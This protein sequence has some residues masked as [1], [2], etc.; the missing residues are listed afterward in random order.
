MRDLVDNFDTEVLERSHEVP[1]LVDF[2]SPSCGP[3]LFLAP[4][5]EKLEGEDDGKWEMVKVNT[6]HHGQLAANYGVSSIPHVQLFFKGKKVSEFVGALPE[7]TLT[8]WLAEFIPTEIKEKLQ[9]IR[10]RLNS[11]ERA[12]AVNDLR[13]FVEEH[14]EEHMGKL[15]LAHEIV[16]T[17]SAAA[18]EMVSEIKLGDLLYEG[19]ENV[20]ILAELMGFEQETETPAGN[21]IMA[22]GAAIR[23]EDFETAISSMVKAVEIDKD[24]SEELP[25]RGSIA[26]FRMFGPNHPLT[27]RYRRKFEEAMY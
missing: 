13:A 23:K 9:A 15:I 27:M 7:G 5:L 20:R 4:V 21:E 18:K 16:M 6:M 19:A 1:V 22:A 3:C 10:E 12:E 8:K 14:P 25:R 11:G 17:D 2:W 26:L 24:F